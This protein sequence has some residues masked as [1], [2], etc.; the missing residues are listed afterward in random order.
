MNN[1]PLFSLGPVIDL[2]ADEICGIAILG[3]LGRDGDVWSISGIDLDNY[4]KNPVVLRGHDPDC[5][6]GSALAIGPISATEIGVRIKFALPGVSAIAD[7][8]RG[9]VKAGFLKGISAGIEPIATVPLGDGTRGVRVV[10]AELLE[11]SF[12]AIPASV[13]ALV[14]A[15]SFAARPGAA[16]MLRALPHLSGA[17]IERALAHVDRSRFPPVPIASLSVYEQ[18]ALLAAAHQQR[19]RATWAAGKRVRLRRAPTVS[20]SAKQS[21]GGYAV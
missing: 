17:A 13:E 11:L 16:G 4:R 5:V 3:N 8:T 6:V 9:L 2:A 1:G 14:T 21:F 12:V 7:E 15:R 10:Q 19:C 20:H 18:T